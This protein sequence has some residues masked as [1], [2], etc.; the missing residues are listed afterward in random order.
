MIKEITKECTICGEKKPL[1]SFKSKRMANEKIHYSPR[2]SKCIYIHY[3]NGVRDALTVPLLFDVND[4]RAMNFV[5]EM[6]KYGF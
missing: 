1:S 3:K 5:K 2:C 6:R 4:K